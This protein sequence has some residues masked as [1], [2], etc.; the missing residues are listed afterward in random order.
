MG[1]QAP[2][3]LGEPNVHIWT[4]REKR[5]VHSVWGA[6]DELTVAT[7]SL[8]KKKEKVLPKWVYPLAGEDGG[9]AHQEELLWKVLL[10]RQLKNMNTV[11]R[12]ATH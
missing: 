2:V 7:N 11:Q 10:T 1:S 8:L 9:R 3:G 6:T 12:R 5:E 4:E